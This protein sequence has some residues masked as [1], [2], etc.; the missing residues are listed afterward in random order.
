MTSPRFA[1]PQAMRAL[2]RALGWSV[3]TMARALR[4]GDDSPTGRLNGGKR[5]RD[6]E[7]G[8]RAI[9]GPVSA[10]CEA[11]EDG[12]RPDGWTDQD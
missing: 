5:V 7:E 2:R 6:M 3:Y 10:L 9:T 8:R 12:F 11:I 1:D 4:L